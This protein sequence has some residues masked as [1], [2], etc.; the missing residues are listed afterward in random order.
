MLNVDRF[1]DLCIRPWP[2]SVS[3]RWLCC[4]KIKI[5]TP[6]NQMESS[7]N[8]RFVWK[9]KQICWKMTVCFRFW[10]L[11]F[12]RLARYIQ[13]FVLHEDTDDHSMI[14]EDSAAKKYWFRLPAYLFLSMSDNDIISVF[15]TQPIFPLFLLLAV[16]PALR[17]CTDNCRI[18]L[19]LLLSSLV[20]WMGV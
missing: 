14:L 6:T 10:P 5:W 20:H 12:W 19:T 15:R 17:N 13:E 7:K 16:K 9:Q 3:Q 8:S 1:V 18:L 4:Q 2:S 11:N